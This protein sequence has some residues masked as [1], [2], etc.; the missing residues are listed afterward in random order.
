MA[1]VSVPRVLMHGNQ[2]SPTLALTL[3]LTLALALALTLALALAL[4][5]ALTLALTLTLTPTLTLTLVI[6]GRH[7]GSLRVPMP[8]DRASSFRGYVRF[9]SDPWTTS[10]RFPSSSATGSRF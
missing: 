10:N 6:K 9:S 3:T 5:L 7:Y 4:A 1:K 2:A 8:R